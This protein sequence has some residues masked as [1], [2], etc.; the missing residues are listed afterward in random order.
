MK[1]A[2]I[3]E[4]KKPLV[5]EEVELRSPGPREVL[6]QMAASGVCHTDFSIAD[7]SL[8]VM[9]NPP[10][11]MIAGHEG[12]AIV[13]EIG[14]EVTGLAPGD[15]VVLS[16]SGCGRC[17]HC[18]SGKPFLC[19]W[20]G[21]ISRQ[22][23]R[24]FTLAGEPIFHFSH[25]TFAQYSVVQQE[26]CIKI[27]EDM[28]LDKACLL[29]CGVMTGIG[30]AMNTAKVAPGS[31]VLVIGC[32][33]VGLN[34]IQGAALCGA[35][36]IIAA[37]ILDNKLGFAR[38]FGATHTINSKQQDLVA[39][40]KELTR[41]VGVDYSF[42]VIAAVPTIRLAF[43][44]LAVN[45]LCTVVGAAPPG[46]EVSIPV[47][48][49]FWERAIRG[50]FMGSGRPPIDIPRL[51]ELYMTKKIKLDELVSQT[52]P[53]EG[54]NQAFDDMQSGKVARTVLNYLS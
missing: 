22:P 17:Q 15:H 40:V 41:G 13:Q 12:A 25:A 29:G 38:N 6:V 19:M 35:R 50:C 23:T 53:L 10:L 45:G 30:A 11:P 47:D 20:G 48:L 7:G 31:S 21:V 24:N 44:S 1:A 27:R 5:V 34:V 2:V 28:P 33:G 46:A 32:G 51:V 42:E 43:E 36:M 4:L 14:S 39:T 8:N 16:T 54:I 37:D 9:P 52:L 18:L 26:N 49:L 3:H